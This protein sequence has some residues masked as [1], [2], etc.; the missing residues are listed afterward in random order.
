[1]SFYDLLEYH[2]DFPLL[3]IG[4]EEITD[5]LLKYDSCE[6]GLSD[7]SYHKNSILF[8]PMSDDDVKWVLEQGECRLASLSFRQYKYTRVMNV[9]K[10]VT[11]GHRITSRL[12]QFPP[13]DSEVS[14]IEH[15][16]HAQLCYAAFSGE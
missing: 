6:L 2:G 14:S 5:A 8:D 12:K 3:L 4:H 9:Q 10:A 11:S 16:L 13:K 1:M 7:R 15:L